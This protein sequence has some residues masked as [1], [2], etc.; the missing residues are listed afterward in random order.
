MSFFN[1]GAADRIIRFIVGA[2]VLVAVFTVLTGVLQIVA[3]V[4]GAI[5]VLTGLVGFCP[6]YALFGIKTNKAK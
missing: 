5:L 6:L 2:A 3:G 1:E 4:V